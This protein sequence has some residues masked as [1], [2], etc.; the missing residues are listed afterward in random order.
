MPQKVL[1]IGGTGI[2]SSACSQLAV[3]RG[4]ELYLLNRGQSSRPVPEG[5]RVLKGDIRDPESVRSAIQGLNFDSVVDWIAF[6]TDHVQGGVDLF[7]GRTGQY[8]FISSASAY[9]KPVASQPITESTVLANP[10]WEY[11]RNKIACE[12]LLVRAYRENGFPATI[13]R[14]S[15]TYDQR[16]LPFMGGYTEI[17]RMRR[18]KKTLVHGDGTSLWVMT[19][20]KDFAKGFLGLLGNPRTI[21]DA[22]HITS[23]EALTWNQIYEIFAHAAGAKTDIVHVPSATI[24]K[25]FPEWKDGYIGDRTHSVIFDNTKVKRLVPD[26]AATIPLS[27]GAQEVMDWYDA[28]P[29]R[30]VVDE[31]L[32]ARIDRLIEAQEGV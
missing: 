14:P 9:Q 21:G 31:A 6:S 3:E 25:N 17:D 13:V 2:I 10:Y 20:H 24:G 1:F 27:W 8:V 30:R 16:C 12:E 5:A 23:D 15:H 18:G 29:A 4:V 28:D 26:F 32:D 19:H 7:T 11:S 22:I